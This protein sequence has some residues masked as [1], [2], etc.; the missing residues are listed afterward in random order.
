MRHPHPVCLHLCPPPTRHTGTR[1][2][3][4]PGHHP[5][6]TKNLTRH[7][8]AAAGAAADGT[9]RTDNLRKPLLR[10]GA[11]GEAGQEGV[12]AECGDDRGRRPPQA[13]AQ[14]LV[15]V[16]GGVAPGGG[17]RGHGGSRVRHESGEKTRLPSAPGISSG[18]ARQRC[19]REGSARCTVKRARRARHDSWMVPVVTIHKLLLGT[20]QER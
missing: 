5:L 15:P 18:R 20:S 19:S 2:T 3:G 7:R 10:Q 8:G 1:G 4:A 6:S 14:P 13:R 12:A 17:G 16:D 11:I 9:T